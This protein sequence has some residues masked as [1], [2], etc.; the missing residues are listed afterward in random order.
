M[1]GGF[2]WELHAWIIPLTFATG[3]VIGYAHFRK[4]LRRLHPDLHDTWM[5]RTLPPPPTE[6]EGP[7]R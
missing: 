2:N 6:E 3:W 7:L 4:R 5:R 1:L